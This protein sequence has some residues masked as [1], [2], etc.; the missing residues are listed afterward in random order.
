MR[1]HPTELASIPVLTQ[2]FRQRLRAFDIKSIQGELNDVVSLAH[3]ARLSVPV[4]DPDSRL[5]R[6]TLGEMLTE[7]IEAQWIV[8]QFKKDFPELV[9]AAQQAR[10]S[11]KEMGAL[12]VH[13]IAEFAFDE[14]RRRS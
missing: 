12:F 1:A 13:V 4:P 7:K 9:E 14:D 10:L 6:I 2:I 5:L 8:R 11:T 3:A